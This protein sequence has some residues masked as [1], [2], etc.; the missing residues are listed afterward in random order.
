MAW[1]IVR[2]VATNWKQHKAWW[3]MGYTP[4]G[5]LDKDGVP[6]VYPGGPYLVRSFDGTDRLWLPLPPEAHALF[7]D[8]KPAGRGKGFEVP[9]SGIWARMPCEQPVPPNVEMCFEKAPWL[10]PEHPI[11]KDT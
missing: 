6:R 7:G 11:F 9:P 1:E 2:G 3:V 10:D 5:G 8:K 4:A